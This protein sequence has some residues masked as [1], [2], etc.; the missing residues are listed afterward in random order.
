MHQE[1]F[2]RQCVLWA[3]PFTSHAVVNTKLLTETGIPSELPVLDP[4][5]GTGDGLVLPRRVRDDPSRC[6]S[7]TWGG[8]IALDASSK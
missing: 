8:G 7:L 4:T 2:K 1:R 5:L 6:L 3:I